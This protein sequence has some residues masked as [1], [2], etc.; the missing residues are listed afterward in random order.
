[1]GEP[2]RGLSALQRVEA[3]AVPADVLAAPVAALLRMK[4][5][6]RQHERDSAQT[7]RF[8]PTDTWMHNRMRAILGPDL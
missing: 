6:L 5:I 7:G 1:V 8:S 4:E 2:H 3:G